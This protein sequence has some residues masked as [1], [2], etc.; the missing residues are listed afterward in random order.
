MPN[1]LLLTNFSFIQVLMAI[2]PYLVRIIL[3]I[4]PGWNHVLVI[5]EKSHVHAS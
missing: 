3:L 4:T 2:Y 1:E 5:D